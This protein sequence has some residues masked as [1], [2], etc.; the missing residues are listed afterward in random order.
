[1]GLWSAKVMPLR[2]AHP[3]FTTTG[4]SKQ[5]GALGNSMVTYRSLCSGPSARAVLYGGTEVDESEIQGESCHLLSCCSHGGFGFIAPR[6]LNRQCSY[7]L[8][9]DEIEPEL[10]I[11]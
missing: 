2:F 7:L 5:M 4:L 6:V 9:P 8:H 1:M 10:D 3:S 11:A